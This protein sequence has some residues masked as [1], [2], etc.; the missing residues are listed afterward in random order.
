MSKKIKAILLCHFSNE[1]VRAQLPVS[2]SGF[3]AVVRRLLRRN[4]KATKYNDF[5]P[6]ITNLICEFEKIEDLELH[7]VAPAPNLSG[8]TVEFDIKG[9]H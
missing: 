3:E 5:A 2:F 4:S 6:W 8:K 1:E 7:V 9:V